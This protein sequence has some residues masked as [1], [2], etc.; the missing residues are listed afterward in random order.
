MGETLDLNDLE[1]FD[2]YSSQ[3]LKDLK[4]QAVKLSDEEFNAAVDLKFT[5]ILSNG[6]EVKL[7]PDQPDLKVTKENLDQYVKLVLK[8]RFNESEKQLAAIREGIEKVMKNVNVLQLLDWETVEARVCGEKTV[9]I[10]KLK[11]ITNY[12][13]CNENHPAIKR[14]W[15]VFASFDDEQRQ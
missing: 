9:D 12:G 4:E 1:S 2:T 5:T 11:S 6:E 10:E 14:F 7:L 13:S 15:R 3:V 8:A